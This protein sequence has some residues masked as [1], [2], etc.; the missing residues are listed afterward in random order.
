M[1][2]SPSNPQPPSPNYLARQRDQLLE[3]VTQ[4]KTI[5]QSVVSIQ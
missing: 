1:I 3:M 4:D 5:E 2:K